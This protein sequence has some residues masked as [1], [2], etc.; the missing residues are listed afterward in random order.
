LFALV[1]A[2]VMALIGSSATDATLLKQFHGGPLVT[3]LY[4]VLPITTLVIGS[5]AI[6]DE[7][8]EATLSFLILRPMARETIVAAKL[9][10]AFLASYLLVGGSTFVT[11]AVLGVRSGYW[12]PLAPGLVATALGTLAFTSLAMLLGYLTS[13]AV[14]IGLAYLVVMEN[15]LSLAIDALATISLI[16]IGL[17]AYTAMLPTGASAVAYSEINEL[18]ARLTPGVFG[19]TAK[20]VVIAAVAIGLVAAMLQRRD[21]A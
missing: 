3:I 6:G 5:A 10:S 1:P 12:S 11:A 4:A 8:R 17:T 13:R 16:R 19:A 20:A 18:M 15:G 2:V 9:V 21:V 7:R 14:L